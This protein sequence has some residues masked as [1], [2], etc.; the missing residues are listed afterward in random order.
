MK[1]VT[2]IQAILGLGFAI[3]IFSRII[4]MVSSALKGEEKN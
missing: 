2:S 1:M 4:T 3:V